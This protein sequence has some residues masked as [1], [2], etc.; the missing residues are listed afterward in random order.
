MQRTWCLVAAA[1]LAVVFSGG[2]ETRRVA[3]ATPRN[4]GDV[5]DFAAEI[6][7]TTAAPP[8]V[9]SGGAEAGNPVSSKEPAGG[10]APMG[11]VP[12]AGDV[13]PT[14]ASPSGDTE[15]PM[16]SACSL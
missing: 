4:G 12:P 7:V 13:N 6:G 10:E 8:E 1:I 15:A 3:P 2:C 16:D 9:S 11:E 5:K 14:D